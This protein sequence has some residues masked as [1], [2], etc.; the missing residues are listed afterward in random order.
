[1][2]NILKKAITIISM[3]ITM[4]SLQVAIYADETQTPAQQPSLMDSMFSMLLVY[5]AVIALFYFILIRP[6]RKKMKQDEA[7]RN[8][9]QVGDEVIMSGGIIGRVIN[10]KDDEVTIE[11]GAAR[12][13][14]KFLK[15]SIIRVNKKEEESKEKS[16]NE[17]KAELQ[18]KLDEK[19]GTKE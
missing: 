16:L 4:M 8:S 10:I 7:M 9:V 15:S 6:Q 12:T 13:Q 14:I 18:R 1:M 2:K 3:I 19:K 5:G 11:S 17:K